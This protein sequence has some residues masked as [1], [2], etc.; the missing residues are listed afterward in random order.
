[1]NEKVNV[2]FVFL[3]TKLEFSMQKERQIS[4]TQV[5]R[6]GKHEKFFSRWSSL[7]Y[8]HRDRSEISL[9]LVEGKMGR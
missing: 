7:L 8:C 6:H 1:M 9:L 2:L 3:F 5:D 4:K